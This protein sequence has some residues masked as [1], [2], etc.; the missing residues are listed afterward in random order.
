MLFGKLEFLFTVIIKIY[1]EKKRSIEWRNIGLV[2]AS[3]G[4]S[5]S[6]PTPPFS[7]LRFKINFFYLYF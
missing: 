3:S 4:S 2:V 1:I 7:I 5:L 6:N